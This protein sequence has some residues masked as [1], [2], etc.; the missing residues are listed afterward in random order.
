MCGSFVHH[1]LLFV[2]NL[3][4]IFLCRNRKTGWAN[5][6][7]TIPG[8]EVVT[9][10]EF[11][12]DAPA[13]IQAAHLA[14]AQMS[15]AS[16]ISVLVPPTQIAA[17]AEAALNAALGLPA[18]EMPPAV[19]TVPQ[20]VLPVPLSVEAMP[21]PPVA[22]AEPVAAVT[23]VAPQSVDPKVIGGADNPTRSILVRNMFNKDEETEQNW[24]EDIRLDFEEETSKYGKLLNVKVMS[25]QEGGKIYATFETIDGA[26]TCASNLAG[27]WFDK[28]QLLVEFVKEDAVPE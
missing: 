17:T 9:S 19:A 8:V 18:P 10:Y 16:S 2:A 13:R 14:L 12:D 4:S 22:V 7:S 3:S 20:A 24:E 15:D 28:R 27:R 5:Q 25:Q 11:P 26:K 23:S 21:V 6:T 1:N